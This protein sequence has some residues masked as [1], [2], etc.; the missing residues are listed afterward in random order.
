MLDPGTQF[1]RKQAAGSLLFSGQPVGPFLVIGITA[2]G[3]VGQR[4]SGGNDADPMRLERV[5][6]SSRYEDVREVLLNELNDDDTK[7]GRNGYN[8]AKKTD[9]R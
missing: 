6:C 9:V 3:Q 7:L 8:S 5:M 1:E 2:N 4:K